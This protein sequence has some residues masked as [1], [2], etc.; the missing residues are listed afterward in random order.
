MRSE[1]EEDGMK[2]WITHIFRA[3]IARRREKNVVKYDVF[4]ERWQNCVLLKLFALPSPHHEY[5][6]FA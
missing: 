3:K 1:Q 2:S 4:H 6:K 5:E